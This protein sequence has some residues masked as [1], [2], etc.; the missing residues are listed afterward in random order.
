MQEGDAAAFGIQALD[1]AFDNLCRGN[2]TK[3]IIGDDVGAG[4]GNVRYWPRV[5]VSHAIRKEPTPLYRCLLSIET[6][7]AMT[8]FIGKV[9]PQMEVLASDGQTVGKV[10]HEDGQD[11]N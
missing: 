7:D 9:A 4:D 6:G 1:S 8:K 10:D 5:G 11:P 2:V 3:P